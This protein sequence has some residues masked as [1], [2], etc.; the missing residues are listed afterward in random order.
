MKKYAIQ[1]S[2]KNSN[3]DTGDNKKW[4]EITFKLFASFLF[5]MIL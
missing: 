4:N 1:F 5:D 2:Q 3:N